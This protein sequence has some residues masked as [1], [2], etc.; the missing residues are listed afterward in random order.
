MDFL[1][2]VLFLYM[3]RD[4]TSFCGSDPSG[5]KVTTKSAKSIH[6]AWDTTKTNCGYTITGYKVYFNSLSPVK[7]YKYKDVS[8]A[9]TN[10]VEI[11]P[12]VAGFSYNIFVKA[13]TAIGIVSNPTSINYT[14]PHARPSYAPSNI[15]ASVQE[16]TSLTICWDALNVFTKNGDIKGYKIYYRGPGLTG[17][18]SANILGEANRQYTITG[19]KPNSTYQF[20]VQVINDVGPGPYS[21]FIPIHTMPPLHVMQKI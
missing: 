17:T 18:N 19:L 20:I 12:F 21:A 6:V 16:E 11:S 8:G 4:A 15:H 9:S 14:H 1:K 5:I 2:L 3:I 10:N 7:N 13:V